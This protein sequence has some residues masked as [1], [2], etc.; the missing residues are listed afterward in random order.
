MKEN[1][2]YKKL[3]E[4]GKII[5]GNTPSTKNSE[6]YSSEDFCFIKPSDID[7]NGITYINNSEFHVS[8]KA[9]ENSRKLPISSVLITC[10]GIIGKVA[11][12]QIPAICNQ[13]INAI[14]P[15]EDI[16]SKFIAYSILGIRTYLNKIANAPVV[17]IINK[18]V[19]SEIKIPVPPLSE[20][21]RIVAE[22]DLLSG[23]IEKQ[24]QQ[25]KELDTLAQSIFY[26]MFGS[27]D[28]NRQNYKIE[29]LNDIFFLIT[30]G[31]HQTPKY[32]DDSVNGYKFLSAKDV[33]SGKINWNNIK[34]IPEYLHLE[35]SKRLKPQRGD[36]LLCKNGTT[37]ICAL[38][39][40]DEIFDIYVSLAL[41]RTNKDYNKK[42]L[43]F[44]INNPSTKQQFDDS[45][46]GIGVPNLHLK[47]IK[48][49]KIIVPPL[50]LQNEFAVKI[51]KI[52]KQ[53]EAI[54]KSIEETQK[55]FDY[56]MDKYF[57]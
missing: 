40:T 57:G 17:P 37:G 42:Y 46:K 3:G 25:L 23:V 48:K 9:F 51:E 30:D 7:L 36:I 11:I 15:S 50:D 14:I 28:E 45:I 6:N 38:V 20:Q 31:T 22:L 55:L 49:T 35:L 24:K 39:E 41:L 8:K 13:Q 54:N 4:V 1:W 21:E 26:S 29:T 18:K 19:F 53:K 52:E 43:V 10:I 16:S 56:T 32:T 34:Y 47:E 12:L 33:V 5:T 2:Q 27:I 44:A